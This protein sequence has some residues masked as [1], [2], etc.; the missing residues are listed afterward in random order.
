MF[1]LAWGRPK[2][3]ARVRPLFLVPLTFVFSGLFSQ[4]NGRGPNGRVVGGSS[5]NYLV[6]NSIISRT[7]M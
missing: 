7:E 1:F 6:V 3:L 5:L 2:S 4:G